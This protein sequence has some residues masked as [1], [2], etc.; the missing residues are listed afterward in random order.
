[1]YSLKYSVSRFDQST[2]YC[3][4]CTCTVF[5]IRT[6]RRTKHE[7]ADDARMIKNSIKLII[8]TNRRIVD[9]CGRIWNS[10]PTSRN[11]PLEASIVLRNETHPSASHIGNPKRNINITI[12][13][14]III[15]AQNI[16]TIVI[17]VDH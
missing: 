9:V 1:M 14:K 12:R 2:Y 4:P 13:T 11:E 3:T 8:S 15:I 16:S 10:N 7:S 17:S 5:S 6:Q